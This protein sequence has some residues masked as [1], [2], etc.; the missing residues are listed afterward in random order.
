MVK[1]ICHPETTF[2]VW[3]CNEKRR[4]VCCKGNNNDEGVREETSRKANIEMDGHSAIQRSHR[5]EKYG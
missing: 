5:R 1:P 3:P 4:Q 2:V